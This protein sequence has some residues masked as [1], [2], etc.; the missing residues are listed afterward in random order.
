MN[1]YFLGLFIGIILGI[2]IGY[3]VCEEEY[4]QNKSTE[5]I[6]KEQ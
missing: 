6:T 4:E 2:G 1:G 5:T 3:T